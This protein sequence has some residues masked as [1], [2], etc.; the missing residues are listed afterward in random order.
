MNLNN[1]PVKGARALMLGITFKEIYPVKLQTSYFIE[2]YPKNCESHFYEEYPSKC[3]A[4]F[5]GDCPDTS[6]AKSRTRFG[7]RNTKAIDIYH[8]LKEYGIEVDVYDPW[9]SPA[10]VMHEYGITS[11]TTL[12]QFPSNGEPVPGIGR[13]GVGS[14]SE[15]LGVG[16][17]PEGSGIGYRAIILAVAHNQFLSLD[18]KAHKEAGA[19]IYDVKGIL[20]RSLVDGKL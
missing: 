17:S 14:S 12:E 8:E 16:S 11:K 2:N 1:I 15:G 9:A 19:V 6:E 10:E 4:Y 13:L 20:D 5:T 3:S 18:L 7:I